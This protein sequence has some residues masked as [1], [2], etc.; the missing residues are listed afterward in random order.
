MGINDI[1]LIFYDV[2]TTIYKKT[3]FWSEQ[4]TYHK[5]VYLVPFIFLFVSWWFV[6][7]TQLLFS[8]KLQNLTRWHLGGALNWNI[9]WSYFQGKPSDLM[10]ECRRS[11]RPRGGSWLVPWTGSL[12]VAP[13]DSGWGE[14]TLA[15]NLTARSTVVLEGQEGSCSSHTCMD[16]WTTGK[17]VCRWRWDKGVNLNSSTGCPRS[18][19]LWFKPEPLRSG[20]VKTAQTI[21][22][23]TEDIKKFRMALDRLKEVWVKSLVAYW[24]LGTVQSGPVGNPDG[25]FWPCAALLLHTHFY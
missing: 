4:L 8:I 24:G 9:A 19:L 2:Q 1:H 21:K 6:L 17:V 18:K 14:L 10:S 20:C 15:C 7:H 11:W 22:L 16:W 23:E 25:W 12:V 5:Y 3:K 13:W